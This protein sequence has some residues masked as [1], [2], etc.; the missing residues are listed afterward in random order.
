MRHDLGRL[1]GAK[2]LPILVS[3]NR[4]VEPGINVFAAEIADLEA[5]ALAV[6]HGPDLDPGILPFVVV[7]VEV[8]AGHRLDFRHQAVAGLRADLAVP[9]VIRPSFRS[10]RTGTRMRVPLDVWA[11]S[12]T[13]SSDMQGLSTC[14]GVKGGQITTRDFAISQLCSVSSTPIERRPSRLAASSVVP[15]PAKGSRMTPPSG[16]ERSVSRYSIRAKGLTVGWS[17]PGPRSFR[18]ALPQ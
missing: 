13:D 18:V 15:L 2:K 16:V 14:R 11:S 6:V 4:P 3:L 10:S 12:F 8:R 7:A 5:V 9:E 17:L 1:P